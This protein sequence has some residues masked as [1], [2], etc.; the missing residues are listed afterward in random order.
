[1]LLQMMLFLEAV[2][3]VTINPFAL[4][5]S[6]SRSALF[7]Q[8]AQQHLNAYMYFEVETKIECILCLNSE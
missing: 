5:E 6:I 3:M 4:E 2:A 7:P 1:M 8:G